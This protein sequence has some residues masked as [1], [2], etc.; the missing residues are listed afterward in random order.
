MA[1][2]LRTH[3]VPVGFEFRRVTE[4]LINM[5]ADRVYLVSYVGD[6]KAAE[7]LSV[8]KRELAEKYVHIRVNEVRIDVWDMYSCIEKF[9]EIIHQETGNHIYVNVSS[10]TKITAIA[11]MLSCM[12]WNAQPYYVHVAYPEKT[13]E[14]IPTE[15][16]QDTSIFSTYDIKKPK[17]EFMLVLSLLQSYNGPMRKAKLIEKLEE[18]DVIRDTSDSGEELTANAKHSQ[19]RSLIDPME[20]EWRL[21]SVKARGRRSEVSM[22]QQ[23]ETALRVFGC[24]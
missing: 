14:T 4:P 21:I 5:Q 20:K 13:P 8:I 10:G 17:P 18:A 9:R 1:A 24:G 23:G 2:R 3:I 7:F 11:G 6:D 15:H 12:M 16:I 22:T 19:L